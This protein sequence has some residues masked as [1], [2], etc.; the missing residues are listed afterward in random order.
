MKRG[1]ENKRPKG[2]MCPV[3]THIAYFLKVGKGKQR[4]KKC[5]SRRGAAP[6]PL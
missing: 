3:N 1:L 6:G 4:L 5:A 2:L